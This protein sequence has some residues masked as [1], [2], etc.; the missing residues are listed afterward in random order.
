MTAAK[1]QA[2]QE[3]VASLKTPRYCPKPQKLLDARPDPDCGTGLPPDPMFNTATPPAQALLRCAPS[4][5]PATLLLEVYGVFLEHQE[6]NMIPVVEQGKPVGLISRNKLNELFSRPYTR[7]LHGRR[8]VSNFMVA[9]PV[10]VEQD[11][12]IDDLARIIVDA[13]MQHMSDGFIIT[14]QGRYLGIGTGHDLLSAITERKQAHLYYLAHYD[15][16]TGLPNRLLFED[17]LQQACHRAERNGHMVALLFLDLDRFKLINDTLG[18][19]V[20]DLLLKNVAERLR[21]SV[22]KKDTVARLGGDEFTIILDDVDNMHSVVLVAQ[23]ILD[24]LTQPFCLDGHEVVITTSIGV[25]FYPKDAKNTAELQ[26]NADAAMYY[27]KESGKNRHQF[28]TTKMNE[29]VSSRLVLENSLRQ[30][31][32]KGQ[33][34]LHY[35][36][37]M[38]LSTK[39]VVGVEAL[40]RWKHPEQGFIPPLEFIPLAEELGLM[41]FIGEYVLWT[42]CKQGKKWQEE[43]G[44]SLSMAVN[45]AGWQLEQPNFAE[46]VARVLRETGLPPQCLELELTENVLLKNIAQVLLTLNKLRKLGVRVAVDDFG[47]GHSSLT[48]LLNLPIDTLK[49][50]KSFIQSIGQ[51]ENSATITKAVIALAHSLKLHV[52][53]EGVETREQQE[54]LTDQGCDFIQGYFFC[55]PKSPDEMT[56]FLTEQADF[57]DPT[58]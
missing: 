26:K 31:L 53:A 27:A 20:G 29:L 5:T 36:P 46:T 51:Q 32:E 6:Q 11:I 40:L 19:G 2:P 14:E 48:Y 37:Q 16:L 57:L 54:F 8:P 49:I 4:I 17:R 24:L 13:G 44:V 18:H 56:S 30:A 15:A 12:S 3:A 25:A 38:E 28:F 39:R 33:L 47:T 35:Q 21:E 22:R 52:V 41:A 10:I 9:D 50:D 42:A 45:L 1:I 34:L 55:K 23:K 58:F 43:L 7:E